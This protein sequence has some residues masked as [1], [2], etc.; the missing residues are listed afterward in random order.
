MR[1]NLFL[2]SHED[3]EGP[4]NTTKAKKLVDTLLRNLKLK[5]NVKKKATQSGVTFRHSFSVGG[6]S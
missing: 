4:P 5:Y 1:L 6:I 2:R 3:S